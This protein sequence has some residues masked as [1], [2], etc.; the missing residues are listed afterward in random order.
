MFITAVQCAFT[1]DVNALTQR[2]CLEFRS[3]YWEGRPLGTGADTL[4][5]RR[6]PH[7]S[8][9]P[10]GGATTASQLTSPLIW[11][12]RP[13]R[14]EADP[15]RG[16]QPPPA[17]TRGHLYIHPAPCEMRREGPESDGVD[18]RRRGANTIEWGRPLP[19]VTRECHSIHPVGE[20]WLA[21]VGGH[22]G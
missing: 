7:R 21:L 2:L 15:G 4:K 8:P 12:R 18:P 10:L 1:G 3:S 11:K 6:P 17:A 19:T 13:E 9:R 22:I 16:A 5:G 20:S 14:A